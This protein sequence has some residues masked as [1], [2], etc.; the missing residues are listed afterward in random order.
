MEEFLCRT[1]QVSGTTYRVKM[2]TVSDGELCMSTSFES[3]E[4]VDRWTNH[5]DKSL[6]GKYR[7][8]VT[9]HPWTDEVCIECGREVW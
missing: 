7:Y 1:K 3:K 4:E 5:M 2:F 9:P 8:E 6:N